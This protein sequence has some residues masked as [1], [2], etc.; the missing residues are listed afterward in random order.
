MRAMVLPEEVPLCEPLRLPP[1][2]SYPTAASV[3]YPLC[4]QLPADTAVARPGAGARPPLPSRLAGAPSRHAAA[5]GKNLRRVPDGGQG[6]LPA[7]V[8]QGVGRGRSRIKVTIRGQDGK[9]DW[10]GRHGVGVDGSPALDG[11]RTAC[12][13][14]PSSR[15]RGNHRSRGWV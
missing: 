9:I 4:R 15:D 14:E 12:R 8:G 5:P 10:Q 11:G 3:V 13:P 2:S 1:F 7:E 6:A